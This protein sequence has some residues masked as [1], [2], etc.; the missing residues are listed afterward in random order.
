MPREKI[1]SA[2]QFPRLIPKFFHNSLMRTRFPDTASYRAV[3]RFSIFRSPAT[4]PASLT[5]APIRLRR[6]FKYFPYCNRHRPDT[7]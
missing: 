6:Q 4:R 5:P 7:T 2:A 3:R 1:I